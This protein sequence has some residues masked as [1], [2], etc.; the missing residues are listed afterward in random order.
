M[1]IRCNLKEVLG[2]YATTRE[3]MIY[4]FLLTKHHYAATFALFALKIVGAK[5]QH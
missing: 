1:K 5:E 4:S 3:T 2:H